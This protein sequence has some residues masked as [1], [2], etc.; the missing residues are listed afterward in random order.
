M[1]YRFILIGLI[2]SCATH[3]FA[4]GDVTSAQLLDVI[5]NGT[6]LT[7]K[8]FNTGQ[9]YSIAINN[10]VKSGS[11]KAVYWQG[12][13]DID[14]DGDYNVLCKNDP[15][16]LTE[17]SVGTGIDAT[18]TPFFVIPIQSSDFAYDQHGIQLGQIGAIIYNNKVCY[19]PFLD[20]CGDAHLI[21][22]ASYAM[23]QLF[24]INPDPANGGTSSGV[25]YIVFSGTNGNIGNGLTNYN[26]HQK[27]ITIGNARAKELINAFNA[28]RNTQIKSHYRAPDYKIAMPLVSITTTGE[29]SIEVFA[30]N[31]Q[32]LDALRGNGLQTYNYSNLKP[33]LYL[34]K[35][36]TQVGISTERVVVN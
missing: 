35:L 23:A 15:T 9:G 26:D 5:K 20:E 18:V 29:H 25:T 21:G 33:G 16:N 19:G 17:L 10:L 7:G 4:E 14:C 3:V 22:E 12:D 30:M 27:A 2:I 32:K 24:G 1:R 34:F 31:G 6:A 28:V 8:V 36:V 13:M 11:E